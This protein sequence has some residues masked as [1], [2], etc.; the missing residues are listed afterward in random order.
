VSKARLSSLSVDNCTKVIEMISTKFAPANIR[1]TL[2]DGCEDLRNRL[3]LF[4]ALNIPTGEEVLTTARNFCL[5]PYYRFGANRLIRRFAN[6]LAAA[7]ARYKPHTARLFQARVMRSAHT[8][9]SPGPYADAQSH[10][11][12]LLDTQK[13]FANRRWYQVSSLYDWSDLEHSARLCINEWHRQIARCSLEHCH[14]SAEAFVSQ[15]F[16]PA[17]A[18]VILE[19]IRCVRLPKPGSKTA[20]PLV[21]I[22][23]HASA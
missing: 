10:L 5:K 1:A 13:R 8:G 11:R 6:E 21:I 14:D 9:I 17:P 2:E 18:A 15:H 20:R 12:E 19:Q 7:P 23:G 3:R 22:D 4:V 16:P